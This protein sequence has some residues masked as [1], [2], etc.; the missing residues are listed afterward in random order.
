M[1]YF[2]IEGGRRLSGTVTASGSKNAALPILFATL[3]CPSKLR[4]RKVPRLHDIKTTL[5]LLEGV[6]ARVSREGETVEIEIAKLSSTEAPY[7]LVRTMRASVLMLGPLLAREKSARVSL[8][9]GCAIGSRPV[10]IHL[11]A[12]EQMGAELKL[13]AGYIVAQCPR[14]LRG[15]EINFRFPSVGATQQIMMAASLAQGRTVI[16]NAAREPEIENLGGFLRAMGAKISGDG[17]SDIVIDGVAALHGAD[18][19]VMFDRIEA[20]TL[21]LAGPITGG[22]TRVQGMETACLE[23]FLGVLRKSGVIVN[24]GNGWV[25]AAAGPVSHGA[26]FET[27]PHPGYPTDLQAQM[28]A[29]LAQAN[30][31]SRVSETI[32]ENRFMHVPELVRM[33][34]DIRVE[35]GQAVVHGKPGCY[36]GAI[37]MATDLRASASLVLAGLVAKGTTRVRRIYHL[38]RG[39]ESL[40]SKLSS[41]GG[42]VLR[43][44]E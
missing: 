16:R 20:A 44:P 29:F 36:Q 18:F 14:G 41:L 38:D 13:E 28:M 2:E 21:L 24:S 7:D 1:D 27:Q 3:L 32:F 43:K 4:L 17:T 40:E 37:V 42:A 10:D 15:A 8:P 26:D 11:T 6:G 34:A 31:I 12:L 22:S 33:G 30:G 9:G 35:G 5:S 25:E 23:A 39:Y 19:E